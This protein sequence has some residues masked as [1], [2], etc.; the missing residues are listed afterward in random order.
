MRDR[1]RGY[2][3]A[4]RA[5]RLPVRAAWSIATDLTIE[6]GAAAMAWLLAGTP[7]PTAV[8]C[9]SDVLA[10]GAL[11]E[12][13][14]RGVAVPGEM[15][16]AGFDDLEFAAQLLPALTTIRVP[17]YQIGWTAASLIRERLAGGRV[18]RPVVDLGFALVVRART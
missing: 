12:C 8:F 13:R 2:V 18:E 6:A 15:A 11:Q 1:H 3:A 7:R 4:L 17:R 10:M 9:A 5:A 14:R 16:I